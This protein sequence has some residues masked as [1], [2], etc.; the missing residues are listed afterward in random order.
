MRWF[1]RIVLPDPGGPG[2][3]GPQ[4]G[5]VYFEIFQ[6]RETGFEVFMHLQTEKLAPYLFAHPKEARRFILVG[7]GN[8]S[9]VTF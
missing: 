5:R 4:A 2:I 3:Y 7:I 8:V 6:I 1:I 9:A